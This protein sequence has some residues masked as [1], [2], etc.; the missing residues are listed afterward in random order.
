MGESER[1]PRAS[2]RR[3]ILRALGRVALG[4]LLLL[5]L[6]AATGV[7]LSWQALGA[8]PA[9]ARLARMEA[10][11]QHADGVFVNPQPLWN[12]WL[13]SLAALDVSE[14]AEPGE[15]LPVRDDTEARLDEPP[16]P[17][18]VTWLGHSTTLIELAG[19]RVLT[20][21][22]FGPSTS[23]LPAL[24]PQRWYAPPVRLEALD[25][26]DV[27]LISHD[28]YDH[29]DHPT[30]VRMRDWDATFVAPLGVGAHLAYWGIDPSRIVELDWW[31]E[32]RAG[33]LRIVATP[34]R[35]ASGRQVF[36]Q[37][38]TLWA[39]YALIGP[40]RRVM[41]SGDTGLFDDMAVI[42]ERYGPFDLVMIEVGAYHRAWP[43]WHIGP[44]QAIRAHSM[45][46][47]RLF[48][49]IHWGLFN[50]AQHGWTEPMERTWVAASE[51]DVPFVTPLPGQV[52][53][54]D[55]PPEPR[56]WWPDRPWQTAEEHPIVSTRAGD[57]DERYP[58]P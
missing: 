28:H 49:P 47:G 15:P 44:E 12:D 1:P 41:F 35:H 8:A 46:R 9:G 42:G 7:G 48:L 55:E 18:R 20:D 58:P 11:P 26:T 51:A 21:P 23:P 32:H 36:D 57:P 10:S 25:D 40:E 6:V 38:R 52:V 34:A 2:R 50:L 37:D 39:G 56:R 13:G 22:V 3:R 53:D 27:V 14:H 43:D 30:I 24:G 29:L 33:A 16:G 54:V 45:M 19:Q 17:L 5:T 4:G 31:E